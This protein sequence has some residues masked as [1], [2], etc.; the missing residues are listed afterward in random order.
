V[1]FTSPYQQDVKEQVR[2]ATD[3]VDLVAAYIPLRHQGR[4]Y[5]GLCPWHDDSRPS[6]Q[7]NPE[8]QSWKCW[9]CNVGGDVFNFLMQ[10]EGI[11][12]REA[13]QM[14]ADRAGI[15]LESSPQARP[16][17]GSPEDKRTLYQALQW[18]EE[19]FHR[20]LL[21]SPEAEAARRYVQERRLSPESVQRFKVGFS[22]DSWQWILDRARGTPFA[23][24]VLEAAD[25]V[26]KSSTSGRLYDTFKG[27]LIFPI[28]DP[29][30]RTIA[31]G[32]RVLP[33]LASE[34]VGK[35][36]NSRETRLFSKSDQ[37]Y[38]LDV[39]RDAVSKAK[40]VVVVEGY[41]DVIAAH[42]VGLT[43]VV[44]VLGTALGPRHIRVLRRFVD[45]VILVL[46]GDEA[47]QRRTNEILDLFVAEQIDL[48]ILTLPDELDPCD[49]L[50]QHGA[51]PFQALLAGAVDALEH[52]VRVATRGIQL[53]QDT[54][55]A[56]LALED[57]LATI[58]K[59]PQSAM[60]T[61]AE[62]RLR[63]QQLL[64]RLARQFGVAESEIRSRLNDLRRP[65]SSGVAASK[66]AAAPSEPPPRVRDFNPR[67]IELL[68]I[69]LVHPELVAQAVGEIEIGQ[70]KSAPVRVIYHAFHSL[71][72]AGRTPDFGNALTALDDSNLKNI[73]VELDER[74]HAKAPEAQEDARARL[75]GLINHF[76]QELEARDQQQKLAALEAKHLSEQEELAALQHL[77]AQERNRQGISA[78]MDG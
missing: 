77:I 49:F 46:D 30:G 28:R 43:H 6:L 40:E 60:T 51:E 7:V 70:L 31:M 67:E 26:R 1:S 29:Q 78:P 69:L 52:K 3:I 34:N 45:R 33:G 35:Y 54:H 36:I 63:E 10:K 25:L 15:A 21:Q 19:Q 64:A 14:L 68:E 39:A 44:A 73:L 16:A 58:A 9:V 72:D 37:L 55:R 56:N 42:Q 41:T 5:V 57:I 50:L 24:A 4:I 74:A 2:Q 59:A 13:L 32:G 66:P 17:P 53:T 20:C 38:G 23:P 76:R 8:R 12:F 71:L 65:T 48:R 62:K 18:A 61:P 11:D 27:R 75:Q 47:G 22:P